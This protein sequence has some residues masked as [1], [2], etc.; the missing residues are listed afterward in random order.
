MDFKLVGI[1]VTM[2][3]SPGLLMAILWIILALLT[4][5]FFFD[6]SPSAVSF[7][8]EWGQKKAEDFIFI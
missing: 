5:F 6:L 2:H 4:L 7:S 8:N 1:R 3:N